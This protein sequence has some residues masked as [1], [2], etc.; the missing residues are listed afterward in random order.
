M[1][2]GFELGVMSVIVNSVFPDGS[3]TSIQYVLSSFTKSPATRPS[4]SM[5]TGCCIARCSSLYTSARSS[6]PSRYTV[7]EPP[8]RSAPDLSWNCC[9]GSK[10]LSI[11]L[12]PQSNY[13]GR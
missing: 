5:G 6:V 2:P 4:E 1:L 11:Y 7:T 3:F 10:S 9:V 12:S 8:T 13:T